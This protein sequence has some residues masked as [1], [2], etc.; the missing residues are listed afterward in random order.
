M[1][2]L[3]FMEENEAFV[4]W[5]WNF[6][7]WEDVGYGRFLHWEGA[8]VSECLCQL[9][10]PRK[11]WIGNLKFSNFCSVAVWKFIMWQWFQGKNLE[12]F[13]SWY[14]YKWTAYCRRQKVITIY[15]WRYPWCCWSEKCI[16]S[17]KKQNFRKRIIQSEDRCQRPKEIVWRW[18]RQ[19]KV[20]FWKGDKGYE[21]F[22]KRE[23][24]IC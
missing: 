24:G 6:S 11:F 7:H 16:S 19:V 8:V 15:R 10:H 9:Q 21:E 1:K 13:W 14:I 18:D 2:L 22:W 4:H 5:C 23:K 3:E 20:E 12:L 17:W